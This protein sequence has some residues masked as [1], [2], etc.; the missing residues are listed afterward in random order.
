MQLV[1]L[2]LPL[3]TLAVLVTSAPVP[4]SRVSDRLFAPSCLYHW[5]RDQKD[6][7][8]LRLKCWTTKVL[9]GREVHYVK[10]SPEVYCF[11]SKRITFLRWNSCFSCSPKWRLITTAGVKSTD[12]LRVR[13]Q[14]IE[15]L[16]R[17]QLHS[18]LY[19][20]LIFVTKASLNKSYASSV[21][22]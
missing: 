15:L 4:S 17:F 3:A 2:T 21:A 11:A 18:E 8:T 16:T 9:G 14:L 12:Y 22:S 10:F 6:R 13:N 7:K 19:A 5:K 1:I 20:A